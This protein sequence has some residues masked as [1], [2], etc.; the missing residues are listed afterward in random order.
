MVAER[1]HA[2]S[3]RGRHRR[4]GIV[5]AVG[6][7]I[8][9]FKTGDRVYACSFDNPKGGFYA[10][11][12]AVA[13]EKVAHVPAA[14]DLE[15]AG[16][17]P[18]TGLTVLP[19]I[20]DVL[21]VNRGES[22]IIHGASGGVGTIA[23]QFAKLRGARVLASASGKDGVSLVRRLGA[24]A[25]VDGRHE[26]IM[27]AARDFAPEGIDCLLGLAGGDALER[28]IDAL[29]RGGRVAYPNGVEPT[30]RRRSGVKVTA[31]DAIAGISEFE[32]LGRAIEGSEA[33]GS[34]CSGLPAREG[35]K[36]A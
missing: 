5:A 4:A 20:D 28:C 34:N 13:A 1:P 31:Y 16:A 33:R 22:M 8:R 32:K 25:A 21:K 24:D 3:P 36:G 29:R 23:V 6:S 17:V 2:L 26:D 7:R 15:H 9:R 30:P 10:E 12:V 14:L 35:G 11:Y 18:T 27:V 19:G